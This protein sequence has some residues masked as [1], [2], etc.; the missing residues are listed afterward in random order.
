MLRSLF[1]GAQ[2]NSEARAKCTVYS[3]ARTKR[4]RGVI[5]EIRYLDL[6]D[7][8][9]PEGAGSPGCCCIGSSCL[10]CSPSAG[11]MEKKKR[12]DETL[13]NYIPTLSAYYNLQD[14]RESCVYTIYVHTYTVTRM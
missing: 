2:Y 5:K 11:A 8:L 12:K 9:L 7:S 6:G 4:G 13:Q 3:R 1:E 10:K 14:T